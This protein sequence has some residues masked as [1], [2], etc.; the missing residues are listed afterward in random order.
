MNLTSL[1][2]LKLVSPTGISLPPITTFSGTL[3]REKNVFKPILCG[4]AGMSSN[5]YH[6]SLPRPPTAS[7]PHHPSQRRILP[8]R[9]VPFGHGSPA[10]PFWAPHSDAGLEIW[11]DLPPSGW[12]ST[13][14]PAE[15]HSSSAGG[16]EAA[17]GKCLSALTIL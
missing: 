4:G 11:S 13:R 16:V 15:L 14:A 6:R 12:C 7:L 9:E 5:G 17:L 10:D 2:S 8:A 3:A 1:I